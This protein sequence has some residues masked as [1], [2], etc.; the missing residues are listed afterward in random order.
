MS[1]FNA[2][3]QLPPARPVLVR[4]PGERAV[5]FATLPAGESQS[6]QVSVN[7]PQCPLISEKLPPL[8]PTQ[9]PS[10]W[11]SAPEV[12][13]PSAPDLTKNPEVRKQFAAF[14]AQTGNL[15]TALQ[16]A[17]W[18][19]LEPASPEY[20]CISNTLAL[21][22]EIPGFGFKDFTLD[23]RDYENLYLSHGFLPLGDLDCSPL[24]GVE[25]VVVFGLS[26][27]DPGYWETLRGA[28]SAG[29]PIHDRLLLVTHGARQEEN[30][31][32]SSKFGDQAMIA[33]LHP[34]DVSGV[35]YGKPL[36]IFARLRSESQER[37]EA[38]PRQPAF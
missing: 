30:G 15:Y 25:K 17:P 4:P 35:G 2:N 14:L 24:S 23:V 9:V 12:E 32:Y 3:Y 19:A 37:C 29:L 10:A 13:P 6:D 11:L 20:N 33:T 7:F 8:Q 21:K 22:Q 1:S 38:L 36:A 34:E 28:Q 16:T 5:Y 27:S 18:E 26:P 31:L